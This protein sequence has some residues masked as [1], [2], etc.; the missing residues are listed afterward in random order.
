MF[1]YIKVLVCFLALQTTT[2]FAEPI[3]T[4]FTY[5]G[6]LNQQGIPASG[7]FDFQFDLYDVADDGAAL[8]TPIQLEDVSVQDGVFT[9]ELDF[10]AS[11]FTGQSLW[12]EIPSK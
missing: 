10:G 3:G 6:E 5:Q 8:T 2:L 4:S 12:L 11:P 9:V 7:A 1:R